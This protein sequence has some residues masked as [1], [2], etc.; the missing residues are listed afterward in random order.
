M[1][2]SSTQS[3]SCTNTAGFPPTPPE[4]HQR[5]DRGVRNG[6][7]ITALAGFAAGAGDVPAHER[8]PYPLDSRAGKAWLVGAWLYAT[9]PTV[10]RQV[11]MSVGNVVRANGMLVNLGNPAAPV[12]IK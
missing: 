11:R 8:C 12:R 9:G 10:P 4:A 5:A 1:N 2:S 7:T 6:W 3:T